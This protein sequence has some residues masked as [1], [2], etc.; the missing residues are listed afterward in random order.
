MKG[1]PFLDENVLLVVI[2]CIIS[3]SDI[4]YNSK[5]LEKFQYDP[6]MLLYRNE[7]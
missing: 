1:Q 4:L 6:H 2:G 7:L 5:L 3:R